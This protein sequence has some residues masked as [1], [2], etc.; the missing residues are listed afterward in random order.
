MYGMF[1]HD[2]DACD[3]WILTALCHVKLKPLFSSIAMQIQI[4]EISIPRLNSPGLL[5]THL[6]KFVPS[7]SVAVPGKKLVPQ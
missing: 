7:R 6:N 4:A 1:V 3:G 2:S 5:N